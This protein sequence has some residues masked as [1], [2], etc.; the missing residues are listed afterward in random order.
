MFAEL[1]KFAA[2]LAWLDTAEARQDLEKGE[3]ERAML[4]ARFPLDGWDSMTLEQYALGHP[5]YENSLCYLLERKTPEMGSIRGGSSRKF[6]IFWSSKLDDWWWDKNKYGSAD[7]AW[8]AIRA[9]YVTL[10]E[11]ASDEQ[12]SQIDDIEATRGAPMMRLKIAYLYFPANVLPV[13]SADHLRHFLRLAGR[14][15]AIE[16]GGGPALLNQALLAELRGIP[17]LAA[18]PTSD[19]MAFLYRMAS[20]KEGQQQI[21]RVMPGRDL[22][23]WEDCRE[24]GFIC[25]GWP[26]VGNLDELTDREAVK[27]AV[28]EAYPASKPMRVG[29]I[30]NVLQEFRS[31]APGDRVIANDGGSRILAVGTVLEPAYQ[32]LA[33]R[34][35]SPHTVAVD[36]DLN[37]AR[38]LDPPQ[39]WR[40]TT[41]HVPSSLL[42][43]TAGLAPP[44][45]LFDELS[46]ALARKGQLILFGPPG[47]GKTFM[48]RRFAV[49][50]LE[51]SNGVP[52]TN[53]DDRDQ[54]EQA[55]ERLTRP[56]SSRRVWW[57]VASPREWSW[58][59]LAADGHVDY[60]VGRLRRNYFE[61]S[62]GDLVVGYESTPTK[63]VVALAR[64]SSLPDEPS[65]EVGFSLEHVAA[66]SDGP[67]YEELQGMPELAASEP[68]RF[69]SQGTLFA[70]TDGE[71]DALAARLIDG[72][73]AL[74]VHLDAT[75]GEGG[76]AI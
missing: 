15:D 52:V 39:P 72:D 68:M 11:L 40:Q 34:A 46:A 17:E 26:D 8:N 75:I 7:E 63:R 31:L 41:G 5:G 21:L 57:V 20:P 36:W 45:A 2:S 48:A 65:G 76:S 53:L 69:R 59:Q 62:V 64:I 70:L 12:W 66:V 50:H 22:K 56:R 29:R 9:G 27:E 28:Q 42:T 25:I 13:Y 14:E 74:R 24:H 49:W 10:L 61:M 30:A 47:T 33:E 38:T 3:D 16:V 55:E 6:L 4:L 43:Q 32:Y 1:P 18:R 35:D 19:L 71:A 37:Q 73:P 51:R 58:G 23:W 60:R 44:P 54:L 67:T